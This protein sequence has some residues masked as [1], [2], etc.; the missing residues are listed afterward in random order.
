MWP[1]PTMRFF[2]R[3]RPSGVMPAAESPFC[4]RISA[5]ASAVP[6]DANAAFQCSRWNA[7]AIVSIS[8]RAA[9][10]AAAKAVRREA[11]VGEKALRHPDAT[12]LQRLEAL[13]LE[14]AADDE[15]GRS[16]ADVDD[17][18]RL[19]RGRQ[20]VRDAVVDEPRFLVAGDD[21]DRESERALGLRQERRRVGRDAKRV[22]RDRAHRRRMQALDA[23]AETREAGESGAPRFRR[24]PAALVDAGADAQILAPG[25]EAKDLIAFDASDLEAEA[26]R[27]HVDDGERLGRGAERGMVRGA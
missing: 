2:S 20:H 5:S 26:V 15:F 14:P 23:L 3:A 6:D 9:V 19:G 22:G 7:P 17:E 12:D 16:A 1:Q 24:E 4:S 13:G 8:E 25:V 11:A 18:P 21:V 27:A 10:S